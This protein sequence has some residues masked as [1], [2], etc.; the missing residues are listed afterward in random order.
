MNPYLY[1]VSING[2]LLFL[3]I[4]FYFFPPKK[5]NNIYGYRTNKSKLNDEIWKF[6]NQQ[7]CS[8]L[9]LYSLIGFLAAIL[10]VFIG[11][12]KNTWQPMIVMLFSLGASILKTEQSLT[13][14]FNEE[15]SRIKPKS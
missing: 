6:A 2:L 14:N 15:G 11:S 4:V 12:G 3:S 7:F 10:L 8:S 9:L 5:I 1:V 13:Q